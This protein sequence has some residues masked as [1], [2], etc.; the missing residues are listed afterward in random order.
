M[1]GYCIAGNY[2][3]EGLFLFFIFLVNFGPLVKRYVVCKIIE[4]LYVEKIE[5]ETRGYCIYC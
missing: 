4:I 3:H 5:L 1:K 2:F